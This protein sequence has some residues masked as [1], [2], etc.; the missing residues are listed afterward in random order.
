MRRTKL[1]VRILSWILCFLM[2][3]TAIPTYA[4]GTVSGNDA[5]VETVSGNDA[6]LYEIETGVATVNQNWMEATS[7]YLDADVISCSR[8]EGTNEFTI[9]LTEQKETVRLEADLLTYK[10]TQVAAWN[11]TVSVNGSAVGTITAAE[12]GVA[13]TGGTNGAWPAIWSGADVTP[14]WTNGKA[15]IAVALTMGSN[16]NT[17]VLHL[18]VEGSGEEPA[19]LYEIQ[20]GIATVNQNWMEA[21]S[22][23]LDASVVSHTRT[24]GTNEFTVVL[25]E[26]KDTIRLEADLLT[27]KKTQVAAWNPTVSVNGSAVGTITAAEDGVAGT[28]GT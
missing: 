16:T 4:A 28:G 20:T 24:E 17:Y 13:G 8:T 2:A 15:D 14:A 10:K 1:K 12:D 7:I 25:A 21:T 6:G 26:Q 5:N 9:V 27:Y 22:I 18:E 19:E 3:F 11:P 23:Y